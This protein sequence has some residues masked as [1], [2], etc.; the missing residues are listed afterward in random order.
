[1]NTLIEHDPSEEEINKEA[2]YLWLA[3]GRPEGRDLDYWLAAK[4]LLRH[5]H[6]R[7]PGRKR[8]RA[9]S[10]AVAVSLLPVAR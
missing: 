1:M 6:A 8:S 7:A 9:K 5:R 10:D 2:Y 3:D 4:E